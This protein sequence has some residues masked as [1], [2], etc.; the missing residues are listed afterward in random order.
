MVA[1]GPIVGLPQHIG[2]SGVVVRRTAYLGGN[3]DALAAVAEGGR[4]VGVVYGYDE[5]TFR[6]ELW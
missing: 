3:A 1:P 2:T 5:W 6:R 4:N